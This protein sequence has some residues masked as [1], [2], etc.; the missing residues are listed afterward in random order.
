MSQSDP[1]EQQKMIA[2]LQPIFDRIDPAMWAPY[3]LS[4]P[5]PGHTEVTPRNILMQVGIADTSVP[6]F[7]LTNMPA[8]WAQFDC[9]VARTPWGLEPVV[10]DNET[11]VTS[12]LTIFDYGIDDSFYS[13]RAPVTRLP[14]R[15][16]LC[17]VHQRRSSSCGFFIKKANYSSL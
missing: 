7:S 12:G 6:N 3:V 9:A 1:F 17:V 5:L 13:K 14:L 15:T 8:C 11:V 16:K 10:L 4:M 2:T